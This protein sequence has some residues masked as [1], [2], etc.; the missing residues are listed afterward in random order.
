M[1]NWIRSTSACFLSIAL[2]NTAPAAEARPIAYAGGW[3]LMQMNDGEMNA[4]HVFYSPAPKFSYGYNFTHWRESDYET[5]SLQLNNL[6]K[7]WNNP[8]SQAN[9]YWQNGA[10][11]AYDSS[12]DLSDNVEPHL[13]TSFSIDWENRRFYTQYEGSYHYSNGIEQEFMESVKLG[14]T[15]YIGEYG[16]LHTWLMVKVAHEPEAADNFYVTPLVRF[17]KGEFLMEVGYS[18][19][20]E[21]LLNFDIIF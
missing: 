7:R 9:M 13:F 4:L 8:D 18:T 11:F 19:N 16:D 21:L 3:S 20:E 17:F 6:L 1:N 2:L 15:P 14:V 12:G 10:G 5:H